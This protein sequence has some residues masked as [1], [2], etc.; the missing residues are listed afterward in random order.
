MI[1][2][3]LKRLSIQFT[4]L[5]F[6]VLTMLLLVDRTGYASL[7]LFACLLHEAGHLAMMLLTHTPVEK[8]QF[9]ATGIR[10]VSNFAYTSGYLKQTGILL[11]G[12]LVNFAVAAVCVFAFD[13]RVLFY[14]LFGAMNLCIGLFNLLPVGFL[15]GGKLLEILLIRLLGW[16]RGTRGVRWLTLLLMLPATCLVTFLFVRHKVNFTIFLTSLYIFI[17]SLDFHWTRKKFR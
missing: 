4:F 3:R 16:D 1:E 8:V 10:I 2:L 5:F 6:A 13:G 9:Y 7:G 17:V 14:S 11:A 15:D 12:S